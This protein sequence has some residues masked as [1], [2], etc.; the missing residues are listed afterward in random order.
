MNVGDLRRLHRDHDLLG[1]LGDEAP[2]VALVVV[3]VEGQPQERPAPACRGSCGSRS[4][5]LSTYG[6]HLALGDD[7]AGRVPVPA[8]LVLPAL[9]PRLAARVL[10]LPDRRDRRALAAFRIELGAADEV[11]VGVV[12]VVGVVVVDDLDRRRVAHVLVELLALPDAGH[13]R[14]VDLVGVV[15]ADPAAVVADAVRVGLARREQQ[16]AAVLERERRRDDD[17]GRLE[18]LVA[19][20]VDVGDAGGEALVVRLDPQHLGVRPDLVAVRREGD[21]EMRVERARLGVDLAAEAGAEAAVEAA[22]AVVAER[23][24]PRARGDPGR[25]GERVQPEALG[26]ASRTSRRAASPSSGGFG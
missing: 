23:V 9:A 6:K 13:R 26:G 20:L 24:G 18:V 1:P 19:V 10:H 5:K 7:R 25:L 15:L 8:D 16:Q 12:E 11:E 14:R 22:A 4:R 17:V 21:R 2:H 3:P